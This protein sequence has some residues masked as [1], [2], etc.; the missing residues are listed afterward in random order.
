M[1]EGHILWA[2]PTTFG[3]DEIVR[4]MVDYAF[5]IETQGGY[6][7]RVEC[8]F[9]YTTASGQVHRVDPAEDPSRLGPALSSARSSVTAGFAD[10][11]GT[12]HINF[13]DGSAI[14][15]EANNLYEAWTINGPENLLLVCCPGGSVA[16]WGLDTP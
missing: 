11:R 15:V 7:L 6:V 5:S 1:G 4:C 10:N 12:L 14:D 2:W 13:A 8:E 3:P 9:I 16:T